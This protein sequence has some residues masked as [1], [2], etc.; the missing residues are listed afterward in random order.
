MIAIAMIPLGF[1]V[2]ILCLIRMLKTCPHYLTI[3]NAPETKK[4][5]S[6]FGEPLR[7]KSLELVRVSVAQCNDKL[8]CLRLYPKTWEQPHGASAH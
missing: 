1:A 4:V 3:P 8:T 6:I 7:V 2:T 5:F